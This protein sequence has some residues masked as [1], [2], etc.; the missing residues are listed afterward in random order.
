MRLV[1]EIHGFW[2]GTGPIAWRKA[3][4]EKDPAF[5]A[6]I[7]ERFAGAVE[8]AVVGRFPEG[9]ETPR[10]GLAT[11]LMLD[12]FT[13]NMWRDTPRAFCGDPSALALASAMI[14]A[15]QDRQLH[16]MER[17]FLYLP[18][19]HAENMPEQ[20]R[21]I[22]LYKALAAEHP[23][24]QDVDLTS[25][26]EQHAAIIRRFGRFPHRNRIL[27]RTSTAEEAAFLTQPGSSF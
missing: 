22:A 3:W 21:C 9:V 20:E 6:A 26:A 23:G 19:E 18:F 11:V 13:R 10:G 15:G 25:Y 2:F 27:G 7:R 24:D 1:D 16:P 12:Q 5:D 8:A 17:C 4:F 14:G